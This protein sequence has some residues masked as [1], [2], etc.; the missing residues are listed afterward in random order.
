METLARTPYRTKGMDGGMIG[1][2]V[3]AEAVTA[4]AK[5]GAKPRPG[6]GRNQ[7]GPGAGGVGH[8]RTAHAG[9]DH[10]GHH[11][12]VAKPPGEVAHQRISQPDQSVRDAA[13]VHEGTGQG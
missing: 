2:M 8:G 12:H 4:A 6:H 3:E 5:L 1:P 11:H 9:H 10:I 13:G 7:H